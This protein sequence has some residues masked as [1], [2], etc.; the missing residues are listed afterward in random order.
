MKTAGIR[1]FKEQLSQYLREVQTGEVILVTDR[2]RVVAEVRA[3]GTEQ[4]K[5]RP[6]DIRRQQAIE[7]GWLIPAT[8]TPEERRE[9][10]RNLK[11]LGL[12]R[13]TAQALLDADRSEREW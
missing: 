10:L 8:S 11:G 3:P 2:G 4:A 5:V 12:P 13:G 9:W 6:E 1:E 7:S